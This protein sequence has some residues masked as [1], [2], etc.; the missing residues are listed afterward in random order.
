MC[1]VSLF[2]SASTAVNMFLHQFKLIFFFGFYSMF[3]LPSILDEA[4][5]TTT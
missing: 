4:I 3:V 2:S 1:T 5:H